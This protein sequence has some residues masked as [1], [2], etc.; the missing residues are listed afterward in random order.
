MPLHFRYINSVPPQLKGQIQYFAIWLRTGYEFPVPLEVKI[1][2]KPTLVDFDGTR[3]NL[4]WWQNTPEESVKAQIAVG[5]FKHHL[6]TEGPS[7]AYPTVFAAIGRVLSYYFQA[8]DDHPDSET[9]ATEWGDE[10][11]NSYY[12]QK[13]LPPPNPWIPTTKTDT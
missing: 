5:S 7:V 1:I 8:I 10:L 9:L 3:C 6:D 4:R 2:N 12:G 11:L 13:A